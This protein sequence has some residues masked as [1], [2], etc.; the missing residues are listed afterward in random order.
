MRK[1]DEELAQAFDDVRRSTAMACLITMHRYNLLTGD[2][3]ARFS[4]ETRRLVTRADW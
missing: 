2:E 1:R 4:D 3:L